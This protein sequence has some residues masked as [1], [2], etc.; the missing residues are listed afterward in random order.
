MSVYRRNVHTDVSM[1]GNIERKVY[2]SMC[3]YFSK[4]KKRKKGKVKTIYKCAK[5]KDNPG[6]VVLCREF[7]YKEREP[8]LGE[9]KKGKL[10]EDGSIVWELDNN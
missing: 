2:C 4:V 1:G 5:G 3:V 7:E 10:K 8:E 9:Y 6:G